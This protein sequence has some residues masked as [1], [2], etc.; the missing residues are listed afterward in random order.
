M[1]IVKHR[2]SG[3]A[4]ALVD[5]TWSF[6]SG[7]HIGCKKTPSLGGSNSTRTGRCWKLI[8]YMTS[9]QTLVTFH[10]KTASSK[11]GMQTHG[12]IRRGD[13]LV[14]RTR[15]YG[16]ALCSDPLKRE[17]GH[18]NSENE[19]ENHYTFCTAQIGFDTFL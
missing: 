14:I 3:E 16:L 6:L 8:F 4:G 7:C 5:L 10:G 17:N 9:V 12:F 2:A 13:P 11:K 19:C 15:R 18:P 1:G